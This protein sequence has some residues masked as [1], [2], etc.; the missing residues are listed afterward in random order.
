RDD[1]LLVGT[2]VRRGATKGVIAPAAQA[3]GRGRNLQEG[4]GE[5]FVPDADKRGRTGRG[6]TAVGPTAVAVIKGAARILH[7]A[8]A[9]RVGASADVAGIRQAV[10]ENDDLAE[11]RLGLAKGRS[12]RDGQAGKR[13][14]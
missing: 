14:E 4:A 5:L 3:V 10:A 8:A 11:D 6:V 7:G 13:D 1:G 12:R 9:L 2:V